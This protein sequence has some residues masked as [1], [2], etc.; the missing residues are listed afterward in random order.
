MPK[1]KLDEPLIN[2]SDNHCHFHPEATIEQTLE[3]AKALNDYQ[4]EF[5]NKF[6]HLMT[7]QHIDLECMAVLLDK[8]ENEDIVVPYF[9]VHPWFSHLF[10]TS[11]EKLNKLEHYNSVL[12]PP[13]SEELLNLLPE[14][15]SIIEHT[16]KM[17]DIIKRYN[18][19]VFGI[20]EIG[21]DKLFR[22]PNAGF[23][24]NPNYKNE[25]EKDKLSTSRVKIDHQMN[26]F[27]YQLKLANDLQVQASIHCVKAHGIL[28]DEVM[29]YSN[30]IVVLHSYTGSID[31]ARRWLKTKKSNLYFSLSNWINGEKEELLELLANTLNSSQILTES[32]TYIDKYFIEHKEGEY[33]NQLIGIFEKLNSYKPIDSLQLKTNML[34]SLS[35]ID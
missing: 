4:Y 1:Q 32:D 29:K 24:G 31:Q 17:K 14:P 16:S 19:E 22:V 15:I 13:P 33:F 5:P 7:T 21:L 27:K 26:I 25:N 11:N 18:I 30:I 10:Y 9:G 28:Y 2:L 3:L 20:G 8:L 34:N 6:F 23:L 12:S 35:I